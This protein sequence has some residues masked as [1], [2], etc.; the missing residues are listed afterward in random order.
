MIR[1]RLTKKP[2]LVIDAKYKT[3]LVIGKYGVD[4]SRARNSDFFQ[5]L[6]YS[7]AYGCPGLLI[8]P[9]HDIS[10]TGISDRFEIEGH[11][12]SIATINLTD[13]PV[14]KGK[15]FIN[16]VTQKIQNTELSIT[17]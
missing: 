10:P 12:V 15:K 9:Q 17:N 3:P 4:A 13:E 6:T 7:V 8:Y 2:L 5:I 11:S 16:L 14:N 1:D